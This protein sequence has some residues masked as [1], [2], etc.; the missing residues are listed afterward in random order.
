M[1]KIYKIILLVFCFLTIGVVSFRCKDY[2]IK[3]FAINLK[4]YNNSFKE[5]EV[6]TKQSGLMIDAMTQYDVAYFPSSSSECLAF[7]D[8]GVIVVNPIDTNTMELYCNSRIMVNHDTILPKTNLL[9]DSKISNNIYRY[10]MDRHGG[11]L[12]QLLDNDNFFNNLNF[13]YNQDSTFVFTF[14]AQ[15]YNDIALIDSVRIKINWK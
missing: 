10:N 13:Q 15:T 5:V 4:A 2:K 3:I 1:K 8:L 7:Y 9:H 11:Y 12:F 14:K 6:Y